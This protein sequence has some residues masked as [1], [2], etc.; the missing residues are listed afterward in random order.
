MR[1]ATLTF[2]LVS[3]IIAVILGFNL[4]SNLGYSSAFAQSY[5]TTTVNTVQGIQNALNTASQNGRDDVICIKAGKYNVSKTL[6]YKPRTY[7][8]CETEITITA[9]GGNVVLDGGKKTT[10]LMIDKEKCENN[11]E[12]Y[13]TIEG[14]TFQNGNIGLNIFTKNADVYIREN[15]F[16]GNEMGG[17]SVESE[18]GS[19]TFTKNKFIRNGSS[20]G[21]DGGGAYVCSMTG[22]IN[23][24]GNI[25]N[26]NIA[27]SYANATFGSGGG[28]FA[29]SASGSIN[30]TNNIFNR[31]VSKPTGDRLIGGGGGA[32][33]YLESGSLVFIGNTFIGNYA[34]EGNGGGVAVELGS[35]LG[36]F[37]NNLFVNN[38]A[39][40]GAGVNVYSE[41]GLLFLV[42]NTLSNNVSETD[43]GGIYFSLPLK[44][45]LHFY[46]NILWN[47]KA[48]QKGQDL[49][50][51]DHLYIYNHD[52]KHEMASIVN[53]A[54]NIFSIS[55]DPIDFSS[56][57]KTKILYVEGNAIY[58]KY[59]FNGCIN[60]NNFGNIQADPLFVS[61][62]DF[63]IKPNSPA[64][65]NGCIYIPELPYEDKA[66]KPR[67]MGKSV[68]IGAYEYKISDTP[69]SVYNYGLNVTAPTERKCTTIVR[70]GS[71]LHY[72]LI[73]ASEN[74]DDDVICIITG[75]YE[76]S[77][78]LTY[79][80]S[81]R[82]SECGKKLTITAMGGKV[83]IDGKNL[84]T[85]LEIDTTVCENEGEGSIT[86]EGITFTNSKG[87]S[88]SIKTKDDVD[89]IGSSFFNGGHGGV[90]I[91]TLAN[92]SFIENIFKQNKSYYGDRSIYVKAN[93]AKFVSNSFIENNGGISVSSDELR[94][95]SNS[96]QFNKNS[97]V[98]VH[99]KQAMFEYNIFSNNNA[100]SSGAGVY[101]S[102]AENVKFANNIFAY[103]NASSGGGAIYISDSD[104]NVF[105]NNVFIS[106]GSSERGGAVYVMYARNSVFVNN[107][108]TSN[109]SAEHGGGV[110]VRVYSELDFYNNI[111]WNNFSD[112]DGHDL[113]VDD[114]QSGYVNIAHNL[115]SETSRKIN[116]SQPP[117][118]AKVFIENVRNYNKKIP[119]DCSKTVNFGNIQADPH[120][121]TSTVLDVNLK[122]D[123]PAIDAGCNSAPFIPETDIK[124]M[125]R[126]YGNRVDIGAHEYYPQ[127]E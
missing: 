105:V 16:I 2:L 39:E 85:I 110:Y 90:Y 98:Y 40:V 102:R 11:D 10:I 115:F 17:A 71:S 18:S 68:D 101:V 58:N 124:G 45:T 99:S 25:F 95:Y 67:I 24:D 59:I 43:G 8:E 84:S 121:K 7:S 61:S 117:K 118:T 33:V 36:I 63:S 80:L 83:I 48:Q 38:K 73:N 23:F 64:V 31:N 81:R 70:D 9:V 56:P 51:D 126:I 108:F 82:R 74:G 1:E 66:G 20:Y 46:N 116:F 19:I 28:V 6:V 87:V 120:F 72:A 94:F 21:I 93:S 77:E 52:K 14:L 123:S 50:I 119:A 37:A 15:T 5:C 4:N 35:G 3:K 32:Y 125:L 104:N 103:N 53:L 34:K 79:N 47:N 107:V 69:V 91:E 113:Y 112:G 60:H 41:G 75:R 13:I 122:P 42:N 78:T 30:F 76:L 57:P 26:E 22:S 89:I 111:F 100:Q 27:E 109:R 127:N 96:F 55:K 12:G 92:V 97:A 106:N 65:D 29:C 62:T 49:Y 114:S 88:V 44:S 86:I 54:H